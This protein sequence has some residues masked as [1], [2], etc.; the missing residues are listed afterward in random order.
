MLREITFLN[1]FV[2]FN[3]GIL[4]VTGWGETAGL[5]L[6]GFLLIGDISTSSNPIV[7]ISLSKFTIKSVLESNFA[8]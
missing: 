5:G 7:S 2:T 8:N 3:V 6:F 4:F 1:W